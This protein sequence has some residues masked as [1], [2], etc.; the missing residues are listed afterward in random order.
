M[1]LSG[2]NGSVPSGDL[3]S[4]ILVFHIQAI[5]NLSAR[6]LVGLRRAAKTNRVLLIFSWFALANL[7]LTFYVIVNLVPQAT[8]ISLFVT[9]EI[10]RISSSRCR[11]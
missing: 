9:P 10:V 2:Q 7:W 1:G 11:G 4:R 5:Y 3:I 8:G 6:R